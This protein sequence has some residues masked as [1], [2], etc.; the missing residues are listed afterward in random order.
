VRP[1]KLIINFIDQNDEGVVI[2]P[3]RGDNNTFFKKYIRNNKHM[4]VIN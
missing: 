3:I 4:F 1:T 2:P